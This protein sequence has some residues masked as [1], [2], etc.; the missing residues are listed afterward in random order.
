[1]ILDASFKAFSFLPAGAFAVRITGGEFSQ[2][3]FTP[4]FCAFS[5]ACVRLPANVFRDVQ[6]GSVAFAPFLFYPNLFQPRV[7]VSS[8]RYTVQFAKNR[9]VTQPPNRQVFP[10]CPDLQEGSWWSV[11]L[12][13]S[14]LGSPPPL[15]KLD[16]TV[17]G[18][19]SRKL[20]RHALPKPSLSSPRL[21]STSYTPVATHP[22]RPVDLF[23][24]TTPPAST[25]FPIRPYPRYR[26]LLH[27]LSDVLACREAPPR[28]FRP[29]GFF[30]V[31]VR[32]RSPEPP[33][34]PVASRRH[35]V[36]QL[37]GA[38][39]CRVFSVQIYSHRGFFSICSPFPQAPTYS[40][41]PI[42]ALRRFPDLPSSAILPFNGH[43]FSRRSSAFCFQ[44]PP[45]LRRATVKAFLA[46]SHFAGP[47]RRL[48]PRRPLGYF[49][50]YS[51]EIFFVFS[52]ASRLRDFKLYSSPP[53]S[54]PPPVVRP[55]AS[56]LVAHVQPLTLPLF[57][58]FK[59][60][61]TPWLL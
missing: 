37:C 39:N 6:P 9:S 1:L 61:D 33:P 17:L 2:I 57:T 27:P 42:S 14:V 40:S 16:H 48:G 53:V 36:W 13:L 29:A 23:D 52:G 22:R 59:A 4:P 24:S 31:K 38:F 5:P 3:S 8:R 15:A 20:A 32:R 51:G 28:I 7:Q 44:Y 30:P 12:L 11:P 49:F 25:S 21:T 41:L 43:H 47:A 45:F 56:V 34:Q 55:L 18:L 60:W 46:T 58:L 26:F 35:F 50:S 10:F 54:P 19:V